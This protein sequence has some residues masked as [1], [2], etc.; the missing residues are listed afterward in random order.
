M[1][2]TWFYENLL[3]LTAI[4]KKKKDKEKKQNIKTKKYS[5]NKSRKLLYVLR[6]G[7]TYGSLLVPFLG[8]IYDGLLVP[9]SVV[10][11][12]GLYHSYCSFAC[13]YDGSYTVH[14]I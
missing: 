2:E 1:E 9:F 13:F 12:G 3:F 6:T 11:Y 4:V 8:V 14:V 10:D 7:V 5:K